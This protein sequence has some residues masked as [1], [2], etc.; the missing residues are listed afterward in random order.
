MRVLVYVE[1]DEGFVMRVLVYVDSGVS[2]EVSNK[3][4]TKPSILKPKN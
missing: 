3:P 1:Q 4:M 2:D